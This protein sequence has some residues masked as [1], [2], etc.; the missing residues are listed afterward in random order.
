MLFDA[1][2]FSLAASIKQEILRVKIVTVDSFSKGRKQNIKK[3]KRVY[4]LRVFLSLNACRRENCD[5]DLIH[6]TAEFLFIFSFSQFFFNWSILYKDVL[7]PH[8]ICILVCSLVIT[9]WCSLSIQKLNIFFDSLP[10]Y[11]L[12][13]W[14]SHSIRKLNI[15]GLKTRVC[16]FC[17]WLS[18]DI[19]IR[20]FAMIIWVQ[21]QHDTIDVS[22][23]QIGKIQAILR[24]KIRGI[25]WRVAKEAVF[26]RTFPSLF[27]NR[28]LENLRI[29]IRRLLRSSRNIF[30]TTFTEYRVR[31]NL[32][33]M[34]CFC[35][36]RHLYCYKI[37]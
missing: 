8:C 30:E 17:C 4:A 3:K 14:L 36:S 2:N 21:G 26:L 28:V 9:R 35:F 5:V 20:W 23:F 12:M 24:S 27:G 32:C 18:I 25:L 1:Q 37:L 33:A 7:I 6:F 19:S 34:P 13:C 31:L 22:D 15:K 11:H 16:F 29:K 10:L